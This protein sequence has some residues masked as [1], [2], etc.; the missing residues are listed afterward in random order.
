MGKLRY[1]YTSNIGKCRK[2]NQDNFYSNGHFLPSDNQGTD[3][4]LRGAFM[5]EDRPIFAVFD[6]M[7]GEECGEVAA[8]GFEESH[9]E[10]I[11]AARMRMVDL[12]F[13]EEN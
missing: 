7:G 11:C 1:Y 9:R 12:I 2:A 4:I 13:Q 5:I 8:T 6:G 10:A 3:G